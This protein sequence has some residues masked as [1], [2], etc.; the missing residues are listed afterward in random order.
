M[1]TPKKKPRTSSAVKNRFNKKTY[2]R[3]SLSIRQDSGITERLDKAAAGTG[4]SRQA[5]IIQAIT[6]KL[7]KDGY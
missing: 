7:E 2:T 4:A 1:E 3:V 5:Y 6:E